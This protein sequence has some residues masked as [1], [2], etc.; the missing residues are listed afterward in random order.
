MRKD[1][2]IILLF[3]V[4]AP[5]AISCNKVTDSVNE[6]VKFV[7]KANE[8]RSVVETTASLNSDGV[9]FGVSMFDHSDASRIADAT[10]SYEGE[11][12][13]W[14]VSPKVYWENRTIDAWSFYPRTLQTTVNGNE[15]MSFSK[16]ASQDED[17]L[18]AYSPKYTYSTADGAVNVHFFHALSAIEFKFAYAAEGEKLET[19]DDIKITGVA[20]NNVKTAGSCTFV[21]SATGNFAD[22]LFNWAPSG[23]LSTVSQTYTTANA[24]KPGQVLGDGTDKKT[25]LCVPQTLSQTSGSETSLTI[26]WTKGGV[27]QPSREV[28]I[29]SYGG[30][31]VGGTSTAGTAVKWIAGYKYVYSIKIKAHG[32][33]IDVDLQVLPWDLQ[34]SEIKFGETV[35]STG[36]TA[37][38]VSSTVIAGGTPVLGTF[39]LST[40]KEGKWLVSLSNFSDFT[41]YTVD[42][43]NNITSSDPATGD[44]NGNVASFYV[45]PKPGLDRTVEHS[46]RIYISARRSDGV[47]IS[48]DEQ[49]KTAGIIITLPKIN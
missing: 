7:I 46:T 38:E 30:V 10:A 1:I 8:T 42:A 25:I 48:A 21:P 17:I 13:P 16:Q 36:A 6:P 47:V 4:L 44:I 11:G 41:V 49:L 35:S 34:P 23:S 27:A 24:V 26:S 31:N 9:K 29:N 2:L 3:A 22:D 19:G 5:L 15:T 20:I 37:L 28:K 40:P 18:C 33:E 45:A 12:D 14:S 39:T 32:G 43:D